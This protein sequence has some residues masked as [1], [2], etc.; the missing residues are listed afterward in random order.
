MF[1]KNGLIFDR[2]DLKIPIVPQPLMHQPMEALL[3]IPPGK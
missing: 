1:Y 3:P 2:K